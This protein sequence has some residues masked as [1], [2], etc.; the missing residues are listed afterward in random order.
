MKKHLVI[1]I[2]LMIFILLACISCGQLEN[3]AN[4]KAVDSSAQSENKSDSSDKKGN[5]VVGNDLLNFDVSELTS[6]QFS[7]Y[8][9][10]NK[11]QPELSVVISKFDKT[12]TDDYIK[13]LLEHKKTEISFDSLSIKSLGVLEL[14]YNNNANNQQFLRIF[15][16][17]NKIYIKKLS[18]EIYSKI[19]SNKYTSY[20]K[21]IEND[22][23][24]EVGSE[25]WYIYV[26]QFIN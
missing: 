1:F 6:Y 18:N 14:F 13:P 12:A 4:N 11:L 9:D 7:I 26:P 22:I 3:G 8:R 19:S 17:D 5:K 24:K 23:L 2:A 20:Y 10:T 25:E 16:Q 21:G 15:T